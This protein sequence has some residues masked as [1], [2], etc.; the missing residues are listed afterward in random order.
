VMEFQAAT[1]CRRCIEMRRQITKAPV[2]RRMDSP[3]NVT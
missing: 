3:A 2:R 1:N